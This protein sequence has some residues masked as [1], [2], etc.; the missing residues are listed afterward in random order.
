M[1]S[2][3]T[4]FHAPIDPAT[5]TGHYADAGQGLSHILRSD[6]TIE[7]LSRRGRHWA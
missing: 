4:V 2:Y 6:F 3:A 7:R 1:G 5:G